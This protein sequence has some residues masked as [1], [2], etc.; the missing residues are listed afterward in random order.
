MSLKH[1]YIAAAAAIIG[2]APASSVSDESGAPVPRQT[3]NLLTAW[4]IFNAHADEVSAYDAVARL[5]PNWLVAHG[6]P[7]FD[8]RAGELA[9]VFIDGQFQRS[10]FNALKNVRANEVKEFRYYDVTTAGATFGLQAGGGG[11]IELRL[12]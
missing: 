11:A 3:P 8:M 6:M 7:S 12:K 2:C 5:R 1:F 4:E 10:G 9:T